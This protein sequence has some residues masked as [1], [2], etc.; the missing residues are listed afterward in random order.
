MFIEIFLLLFVIYFISLIL[1]RKENLPPGPSDIKYVDNFPYIT[2]EVCI[3][4]KETYGNIFSVKYGGINFVYLC[5]F[6][7]AK[8][9]FS[10]PEFA[11]RPSWESYK[12]FDGERRQNE[13]CGIA[14]SNGNQWIHNRRFLLHN[15]RDLGMGKSKIEGLMM[16]EVEDLVEEFKGLT[17]VPTTIP[18][19]INVAI[20]NV[21]WQ[22][23]SSKI[24]YYH[25]CCNFYSCIKF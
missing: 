6:K 14:F 9:C 19:V 21:I 12:I 2:N 10:K 8:E 11:D 7:T 17:K 4:A 23:F 22:L 25:N 24:H 5:D 18:K 20:T 3:A 16:R 15:L 1:K 13:A